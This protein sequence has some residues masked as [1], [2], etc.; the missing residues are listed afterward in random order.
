MAEIVLLYEGEIGKITEMVAQ[1]LNDAIQRYSADQI[2]EAIKEAVLRGKR[3][4]KYIEGILKNREADGHDGNRQQGPSPLEKYGGRNAV[5]RAMYRAKVKQ[6]EGGSIDEF[7][8][9]SDDEL[10]TRAKELGVAK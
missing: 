6:G 7:R 5:I 3:N 10:L 9:K 4:W 2:K 8:G 1:A